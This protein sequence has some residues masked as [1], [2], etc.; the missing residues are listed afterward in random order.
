MN[1]KKNIAITLLAIVPSLGFADDNAEAEEKKLSDYHTYFEI[2]DRGQTYCTLKK[3]DKKL[4]QSQLNKNDQSFRFMK[5]TDGDNKSTYAITSDDRHLLHQVLNL[6]DFNKR[7]CLFTKASLLDHNHSC[8][9]SS[10]EELDIVDNLGL[11]RDKIKSLNM[12][13]RSPDF[14]NW[15]SLMVLVSDNEDVMKANLSCYSNKEI[16]FEAIKFDE[17]KDEE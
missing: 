17:I 11:D 4:L 5:S 12:I 8:T 16:K 9:L 13:S 2:S 7:H 15:I 1:I 3:D 14:M 10:F 6:T